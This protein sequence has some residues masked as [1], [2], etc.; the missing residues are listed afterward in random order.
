[1][2]DVI[3]Q[4]EHPYDRMKNTSNLAEAE[5]NS[6]KLGRVI[7]A[8]RKALGLSQ[9]E[10]SRFAGCGL[11]FLYELETGK[12]TVRMDKLLAVLQVLGLELRV[13][14]GKAGILID[15]KLNAD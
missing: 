14:P 8:Q 12:S 6:R 15:E 2:L 11:A 7:R 4:D 5:N 10:L 13:E 9:L 1:M 3:I